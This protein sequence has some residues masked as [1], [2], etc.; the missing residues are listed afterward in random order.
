MRQAC[1]Q[2]TRTIWVSA[3]YN[4]QQQ[5][6][7]FWKRHRSSAALSG[8]WSETY[9]RATLG[10]LLLLTLSHL[11]G[12]RL[13]DPP[14]RVLMETPVRAAVAPRDEDETE[15][16]SAQPSSAP[17]APASVS[18]VRFR[19]SVAVGG[20]VASTQQRPKPLLCVGVGMGG[21]VRAA[22]SK[23]KRR[24]QDGDFDLDL[25]YITPRIIAM[26]FP[27][28]G[29]E[30]FFRNPLAEVQRFFESRHPGRYRVYNLCSERAYDPI[31][32]AGRATRYPFDDHNPSCFDVI[33][34][35]CGDADAWLAA[36]PDNVI[37]V[38]CKVGALCARARGPFVRPL[39]AVSL[40][41]DKHCAHAPLG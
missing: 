19:P 1:A 38:H 12:K 36:H 34:A 32:F 13:I 8:Y 40:R 30:G 23:K 5:P 4:S 10:L 9:A 11:C 18:R 37:A 20:A 17:A 26:G 28:T 41:V 24:F 7:T 29:R 31:E 25:T 39:V 2:R 21:I 15:S 3:A 33:P 16:L 35:F 6:T 22:V 27:S 14:S